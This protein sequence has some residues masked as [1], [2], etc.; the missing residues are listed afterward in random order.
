MIFWRN[1]YF[2]EAGKNDGYS[3]HMRR[4]EAEAQATQYQL[5]SENDRPVETEKV[6][7]DGTRLGFLLV[8][9]RYAEHALKEAS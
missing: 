7:C 6:E 4:V 1:T 9:K 5:L 3:W 8:L 2:N